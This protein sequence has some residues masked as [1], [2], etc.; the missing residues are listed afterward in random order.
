MLPYSLQ[1]RRK[2]DSSLSYVHLM[3]STVYL[4][5][6]EPFLRLSCMLGSSVFAT[7]SAFWSIIT[8]TAGRLCDQFGTTTISIPSL[9][10]GFLAFLL[11]MGYP[12]KIGLLIGANLLCFSLYNWGRSVT[13]AEFSTC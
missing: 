13:R 7:F 3:S 12:E 5:R 10:L 9:L 6:G 2:A 11:L 8:P 1:V 4:F